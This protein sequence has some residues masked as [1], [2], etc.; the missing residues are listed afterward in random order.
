MERVSLGGALLLLLE[1]LFSVFKVYYEQSLI[2]PRAI[3]A[4]DC[5]YL[6]SKYNHLLLVI[7]I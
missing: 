5:A 4:L 6:F 2:E 3:T 1:Y 7:I